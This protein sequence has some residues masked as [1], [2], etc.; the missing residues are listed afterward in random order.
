MVALHGGPGYGYASHGAIIRPVLEGKFCHCYLHTVFLFSETNFT[1]NDSQLD[2]LWLRESVHV[3]MMVVMVVMVV[4]V[5]LV[6]V[7]VVMMVVVMV[8]ASVCGIVDGWL[9][10]GGARVNG[11][12]N[13]LF[14]Q[15]SLLAGLG[16]KVIANQAGPV[17]LTAELVGLVQWLV[18]KASTS[19]TCNTFPSPPR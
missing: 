7:M 1:E 14:S 4:V 3:M 11:P 18:V 8:M 16:C 19:S 10:V 13:P 6:M 2:G 9:S 5:M 17:K 15:A 12:I